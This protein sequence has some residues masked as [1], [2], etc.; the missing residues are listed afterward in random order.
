M[1]KAVAYMRCSGLGQVDGD[2]WDRQME[3][4]SNSC[5]AIGLDLTCAYPEE[6]VPGKLDETH[7]PA[8][9]QMILDLLGNGCRVIVV[10]RLQR[11]A[12]EYAVQQSLA[13]YIASKGLTLIAA[14]TQEDI[15]AALIGD[16][17]K[18][19][20]IQIQGVFSE[21]DKN[22]TIEKLGKA[23]A[24][25]RGQGRRPHQKNYSSDPV[26][27]HHAEG[28]LRF[29]WKPGEDAVLQR[30]HTL[31]SEDNTLRQIASQ[32]NAEGIHGRYG[33][34]WNT[35]TISRILARPQQSEEVKK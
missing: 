29:G 31:R 10:E 32:L 15:T 17:M 8:F 33:K 28:R 9:Q 7:R 35:G 14:D 2:T 4:I 22:L 5:A 20:L 26:K 11:L 34:P 12:R 1:T 24:R 19:A 23:R 27:N 6:G 30:I 21:L 13:M 16:P 3:A 25:I 18:R